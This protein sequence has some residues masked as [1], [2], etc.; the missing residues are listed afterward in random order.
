MAAWATHQDTCN[1]SALIICFLPIDE[2]LHCE[3]AAVNS[4]NLQLTAINMT[5]PFGTLVTTA[6]HGLPAFTDILTF[7]ITASFASTK[8]IDN[9]F[10]VIIKDDNERLQKKKE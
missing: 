5:K 9:I 7:S 4:A 1:C 6:N 8:G 3:K 2:E 10:S